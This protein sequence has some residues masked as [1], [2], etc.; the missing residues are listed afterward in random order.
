MFEL[1]EEEVDYSINNYLWNECDIRETA[2]D[3]SAQ[4]GLKGDGRLFLVPAST[5]FQDI[6]RMLNEGYEVDALT[7]GIKELGRELNL[8][9]LVIDTHAGMNEETLIAIAVSDAL[10][11]ILRPDRQDYLGTAVM[12]D[13]AH[14]LRVTRTVLV[15]NTVPTAFNAEDVAAKIEQAYDHKVAALLP[16]S[17]EMIALASAGIFALKYPNHPI[18]ADMRRIVETLFQ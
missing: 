15:V 6:A 4:L 13:V 11:I 8:D 2:Y 5:E 10:V 18:T 9:S 3:L 1:Q 12:V 7:E 17:E 14:K 16:L